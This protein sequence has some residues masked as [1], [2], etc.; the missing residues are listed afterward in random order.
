M[1]PLN[2][3]YDLRIMDLSRLS[4]ERPRPF[5]NVYFQR[6]IL[7]IYHI[8]MMD[9]FWMITTDDY[10][11]KALEKGQTLNNG[12][13]TINGFFIDK[14]GYSYKVRQSAMR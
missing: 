8:I 4:K 1:S 5:F 3:T 13:T 12:D 7:Y 9:C 6:V 10:D 11:L 14:F 2:G